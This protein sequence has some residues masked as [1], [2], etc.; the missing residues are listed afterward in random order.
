MPPEI[1]I[2]DVYQAFIETFEYQIRAMDENDIPT[3]VNI[4]RAT[5]RDTSWLP[6][7]FLDALHDPHYNC[8][9]LERITNG[10]RILGYGLQK[11]KRNSSHIAN[12]C[13]H[14][15]Q[16]GH[17]LGG[18]LLH[19]MIDHARQTGASMIELEVDTTNV[20]AYKLYY[21]HG[22]RKNRTFFKYY[23]DES[24]AYHMT[25]SLI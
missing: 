9:I 1:N 24:D 2:N 21:N 3:V 4:E 14:P 16:R 23:S 5:W 13:I 18:I 12:L 7:D 25:L 10:H 11:A 6:N 8:W 17:G 20:H 19:H 15:S 22:F